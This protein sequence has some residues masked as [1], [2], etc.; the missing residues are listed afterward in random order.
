MQREDIATLIRQHLDEMTRRFDVQPISLFG[1]VGR[2]EARPGS[3]V[4]ILVRFKDPVRARTFFDL[5]AFL[6]EILACDVDLATDKMIGAKLER[7]IEAYRHVRNA[8][9]RF[10]KT[11]VSPPEPPLHHDRARSPALSWTEVYSHDKLRA[12]R[13]PELAWEE[14]SDRSSERDQA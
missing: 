6:E 1:S 10:V 7:T 13:S 14:R 8:E 11:V 2:N 4:D 12:F 9:C 5:H 3:D